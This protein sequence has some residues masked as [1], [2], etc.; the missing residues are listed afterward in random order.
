MKDGQDHW[1]GGKAGSSAA[2]ISEPMTALEDLSP[3][4]YEAEQ[5]N[6]SLLFCPSPL[7]S[8]REDG[9]ENKTSREEAEKILAHSWRH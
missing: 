6:V 8:C 9:N 3:F 7:P 5:P 1:S 2:G 4:T